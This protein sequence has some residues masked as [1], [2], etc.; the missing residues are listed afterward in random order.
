[1]ALLE[2]K[3][4]SVLSNTPT[5]TSVFNKGK[6]TVESIKVETSDSSSSPPK[7]LLI[8][9]PTIEG[10]YPVV[11]FLHGFYLRNYF[12][13]DLLHH[14]SSHGVIIVAPQVFIYML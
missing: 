3:T 7:P 4:T 13:D 2:A 9:T 8:V 6:L 11:L 14:I 5:T 1:M 10:T 12:Y